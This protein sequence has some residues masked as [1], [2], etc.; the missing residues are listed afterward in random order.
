MTQKTGNIEDIW[1]L[2]EEA[3]LNARS[4]RNLFGFKFALGAQGKTN[5]LTEYGVNAER[6]ENGPE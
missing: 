4:V 6:L 1:K 2:R 3:L 5:T